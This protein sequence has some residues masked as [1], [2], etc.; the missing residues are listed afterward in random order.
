MSSTSS[1]RAILLALAL[2]PVFPLSAAAQM[3]GGSEGASSMPVPGKEMRQI[4]RDGMP[5]P[6]CAGMPGAMPEGPGAAPFSPGLR[7]IELTEAQED[8]IFQVRHAQAPALREAMK[9]ARHAEEELRALTLAP[10]FDAARAKTLAETAGKAHGEIALLHATEASQILAV[11]TPAQRNQ[12]DESAH[13]PD[14]DRP[15]HSP[16]RQQPPR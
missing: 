8:R 9:K 10:V 16:A 2:L 14:K 13:R 1:F 12:H 7:G 5:P 15:E 11:L 4:G 3:P 6:P